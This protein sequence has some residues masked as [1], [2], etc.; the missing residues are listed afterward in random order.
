MKRAK[1]MLASLAV[2]AIVGS[3][4]AATVANDRIYIDTN[5]DG[6]ADTF[7][8]GVKTT[9]FSGTTTLATTAVGLPVVQKFIVFTGNE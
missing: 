7:V 2:F 3:A 6:F 1:L 4:V 8:T 9:T 5:G